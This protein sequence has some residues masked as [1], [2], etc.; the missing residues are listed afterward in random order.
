MKLYAS[1]LLAIAA[2]NGDGVVPSQQAKKAPTD[3][4]QENRDAV[5]LEDRDIDLYAQRNALRL[6]KSGTGVR[7]QMLRDVPGDSIRTEQWAK[8]NYRMEL[9]NGD[10]AYATVKGEPESFLVG[11]D[12]VESGLHEAIQHLSPGDSAVIVIPSYRAHGLIGDQD[13]VPMR[14]SVVYRIGLVS[15]TPDE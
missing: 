14:S 5:K 6:I 13:K 11:M 8:V 9:L 10:T 7:H 1:L 3:L 2:C 15:V 4:V 12:N